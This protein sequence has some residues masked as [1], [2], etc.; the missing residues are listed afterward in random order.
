M[1]L[2]LTVSGEGQLAT[3]SICDLVRSSHVSCGND[4]CSFVTAMLGAK[5]AISLL[6]LLANIVTTSK[7]LVTSDA[8]VTTRMKMAGRCEVSCRSVS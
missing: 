7:A 1:P 5:R 4:C 8:L 2:T 3:R 6:F